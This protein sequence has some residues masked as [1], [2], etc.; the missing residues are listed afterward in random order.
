M[1][2]QPFE[3]TDWPGTVGP[4]SHWK[5]LKLHEAAA[6]KPRHQV[7]S[8][9]SP[10]SWKSVDHEAQPRLPA[11]IEWIHADQDPEGH[12]GQRR[13]DQEGIVHDF[14]IFFCEKKKKFQ[15]RGFICVNSTI[16]RP[17]LTDSAFYFRWTKFIPLF[18]LFFQSVILICIFCLT[19]QCLK[20]CPWTV[21]E[22]LIK[23]NQ[24]NFFTCGQKLPHVNISIKIKLFLFLI[25]LYV[26]GGIHAKKLNVIGK[27]NCPTIQKLDNFQK[28]RFLW[29]LYVQKVVPVGESLCAD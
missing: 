24:T 9:C 10:S 12:R 4:E 17:V 20:I 2:S 16:L 19:C 18:N 1:A 14:V 21:D 25:K 15:L 5:L 22:I 27:P 6:E 3:V 8:P 26:W 7:R 28:M 11:E 29:L 23:I 13:Y